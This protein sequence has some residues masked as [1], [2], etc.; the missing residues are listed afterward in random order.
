MDATPR[1]LLQF[2]S[3]SDIFDRAQRLTAPAVVTD[4]AVPD[5]AVPA[6]GER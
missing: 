3:V 6:G 4:D 5:G 2:T 1:P